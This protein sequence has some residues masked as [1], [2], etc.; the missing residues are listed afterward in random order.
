MKRISLLSAAV[1][2]ILIAV[3]IYYFL[4]IY[5]QQINF[6]K[7]I[8]GRQ[9]E[10]CS[11]EI[12][13]QMAGLM[14]EI[15]FVLDNEDI[16]LFFDD[17][18]VR[19]NS[20]RKIEIFFS[21]Y[22]DLVTEITFS[23]NNKH[24]LNIFKDIE[25]ELI[26]D[27]YFSRVQKEL[28]KEKKII[29]TNK[30]T[31][32]IIPNYR[33]NQVLANL[34]VKLDPRK[35]IESVFKNYHI[36]QTLCQWVLNHDGEIFFSNFN[37]DIQ[38][39][40]AL[41]NLIGSHTDQAGCLRHALITEDG[42]R[43]V[44]SSYYPVQLINNKMLVVFS[45]DSS[46]VISYIINSFLTI[47]SVTFLVLLIVIVF[48]FYSVYNERGEKQKTRKSE[49]DLLFILENLP[50]G[51][52]I[53]GTDKKIKMINS[54][55][56][57]ILKIGS[58]D[59]IT[60]KDIS[61]M[62]FLSR[63]YLKEE[64]ENNEREFIFYGHDESDIHLYK[65]ELPSVF[66]GEEVIVEAFMDISSINENRKNE[67]AIC[68]AK[69]E[70]LNKISFDIRNSLNGVFNMT[71]MLETRIGRS[72]GKEEIGFI[73]QC[74]EEILT[75]INDINH[76]SDFEA[77]HVMVNEIPFVLKDEIGITNKPLIKKAA[78]KNI[79]LDV[80]ITGDTPG[81]LI[82]DP[83]HLKQ[84]LT[85]LINNSL[86]YT[87]EGEIK[88]TVGLKRKIEENILLEFI[89]ED[90]GTGISPG[91]LKKIKEISTK[92]E[93]ISSGY[94]LVK[95]YQLINL[96][97]GE[98]HIESPAFPEAAKWGP[99]TR[100][101]FCMQFLSDEKSEK[102]ID[103]S[104]IKNYNEICALILS[105]QQE[106][107][108]TVQKFL[109]QY[110]IL[111]EST[112][113]NDSTTEIIKSRSKF[114]NT[115]YSI[116]IIIDS[117]ESNG[118]QIARDIFK[119]NLHKSSLVVIV[120]S[121][122]KPGNIIKSR[123]LGVDHYLTEPSELFNVIQDNFSHINIPLSES[124]LIGNVR[125]GIKVLVA[126]DNRV[127]QI[128]AQSMFKSLGYE[129]DLAA[130]GKEAIDMIRKTDY[131]IVFLDINMPVK[132][133]LD[134][135]YELRKLGYTMPVVAITANTGE[136]VR[137]QAL[138]AGMNDFIAKPVQIESLKN[139]LTRKFSV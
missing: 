115:S 7:T 117:R 70:F 123:R 65:K 29:E 15:D 54:T 100:I 11:Q 18:V 91:I 87:K 133:G 88:L 3:N 51:I 35:Y 39:F 79:G 25:N 134:A 31:V 32:I 49:L 30:E 34:E 1:I 130:N 80:V 77:G 129:I 81:K 106:T 102:N 127:N 97:K 2:I 85:T 60:G 48:L 109:K 108:I 61:G 104:N 122:K 95:T 6:Q 64:A 89:L 10:I 75:V 83:D 131:D 50:V 105:D 22:N 132:N 20:Y 26:T 17:P 94:G 38:G 101:R 90:T 53:K 96:M 63:D 116:I 113:Y 41:D 71:N 23:D 125:P 19:D 69:T 93:P 14:S 72:A 138:Q 57:K 46:I 66:L 12:E 110:G 13:K 112:N 56:L 119:N 76:F 55:A 59:E 121:F 128:V 84:V 27:I 124:T 52:L 45:L 36:D 47:S 21:K 67:S 68:E 82:G 103:F 9:T 135:A 118:F 73:R 33:K 126:E 43:R 111:Y 74:C 98:M 5:N 37:S 114:S 4:N 8:L 136:N 16:F 24:V 120:S 28:A 42:I 139:L 107:S 58:A 86:R 40:G 92:P 78:E 44:I 62:F 137:L 99:G